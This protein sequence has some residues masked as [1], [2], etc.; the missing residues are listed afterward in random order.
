M[1]D[2]VVMAAKFCAPCI[3]RHP[4]L[5]FETFLLHEPA[6]RRFQFIFADLGAVRAQNSFIVADQY[7]GISNLFKIKN[8]NIFVFLF[9][10]LFYSKDLY[11]EEHLKS[12]GTCTF[13]IEINM[14]SNQDTISSMIIFRFAYFSL[15]AYQLQ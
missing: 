2:D 14:L 6:F 7:S 9:K 13:W 8:K 12:G 3:E 10:I 11:F 1:D 4:F 15:L 5:P